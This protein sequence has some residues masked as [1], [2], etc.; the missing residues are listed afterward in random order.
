MLARCFTAIVFIF[1]LAIVTM[2]N[3]AVGLATG[4][5]MWAF[6]FAD[7]T[8]WGTAAFVLNYIPILGPLVGVLIFFA[9]GLLTFD[10]PWYAIF[11]AGGYLLI[12]IIEGENVT[13]ILLASRLTLN[14][15]FVLLS[16]FCWYA[17]WGIPGALLAVPLFAIFKIFCD[18]VDPLK[19]I[20]HLIGS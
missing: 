10:S 8:L 18:R 6:G 11:P 3:A 5:L 7:P 1:C 9:A 2:M 12:H 4:V 17:L 19:P 15:I 14:P 16:V 20:G 13:P